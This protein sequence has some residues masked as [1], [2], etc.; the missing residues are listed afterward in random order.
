MAVRRGRRAATGFLAEFWEFI[1]RGN[2]VDLA[3]AFVIGSAFSKIVDSLV[4]DVVAPAIL[5][6]ALNAANVNNLSELAYG[7]IKYGSFLAAVVNFL[8][9]AF[10]AFV[11][12][13]VYESF[14]TR[15]LRY[16]EEEV[17]PPA[18]PIL[19]SQERLTDAIDRLTQTVERRV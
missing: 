5:T 18:D 11:A 4:S 16:E 6:P 19:V 3:V 9:I 17:V 8:V 14:R 7:N 15:F 12:I 2:V 10:S 1:K 13:R